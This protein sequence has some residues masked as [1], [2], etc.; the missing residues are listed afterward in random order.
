MD[1]HAP[2]N[3]WTG[4]HTHTSITHTSTHTHSHKKCEMKTG[5]S[6]TSIYEIKENELK[7][8][9]TFLSSLV[10]EGNGSNNNNNNKKVMGCIWNWKLAACLFLEWNN[11][12]VDLCLKCIIDHPVS[13]KES[14]KT[15]RLVHFSWG[16][17]SPPQ[18]FWLLRLWQSQ[19]SSLVPQSAPS[20]QFRLRKQACALAHCHLL[21]RRSIADRKRG[22]RWK[23]F[24]SFRSSL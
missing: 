12:C 17:R 1:S 4:T 18:R 14:E 8:Q 7:F 15:N 11:K 2:S 5:F 9:E 3:A 16:V 20:S 23:S 13:S 19:H 6:I 10:R 22:E 21:T 24:L